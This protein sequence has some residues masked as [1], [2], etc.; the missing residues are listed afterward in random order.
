MPTNSDP[1]RC[2]DGFVSSEGGVDSNSDPALLPANELAFL[3]NGSLRSNFANTRPPYV[4]RPLTFQAGTAMSNFTGIFQGACFYESA[5]DMDNGLIVSVGGHLFKIL[6]NENFKVN[7]ITPNV[8]DVVAADFLVPAANSQV[9]VNVTGEQPFSVNQNLIIDSGIYVVNTILS[10]Q[11]VLTYLSSAANATVVEGTAIFD[12]AGNRIFFQQTNPA[13]ADFVYLYQA[14]NYV[15]GLCE[16]QKT[17][18]YDGSSTAISNQSLSQLPS[19][20]L[21]TYAWGRNWLAQVDGH[22]FIASDLVG[23]PSGTPSLNYVDAILKVT[24]NNVLNGGGSFSTPANLGNITAM[25]VLSQ[26]D[27]SLGIGPVLVG[28]LNSIFS[29]QAPVDRTTWQNLTFPIQSVAVQGSGP[30]GP[31]ALLPVNSDA[32]YRSLDG[33]RSMVAARRDFNTNLSNT[34]NSIEMSLVFDFDDPALLFY[35]SIASFDNRILFTA[36]PFRNINGVAHRGIVVLNQD[37]IS[38]IK[39][40]GNPIWEGLWTGLNVL[41]IVTGNVD[42]VNRCFLFVLNS[43]NN[44]EL[45]EITPESEDKEDDVSITFGTN[46]NLIPNGSVYSFLGKFNLIGILAPSTSYNVTFGNNDLSLTNTEGTPVSI[47]GAPGVFNFTT[48]ASPVNLYLTKSPAAIGRT[49]VTATISLAPNPTLV[50]TQ[51]QSWLE[52]RL[53]NFSD[54]FQL[55]RLIM[56]DLNLDKITDN[57]TMK[58][59]WRPDQYP[60]WSLWTTFNL[61]ANVSQCGFVGCVAGQAVMWK[62]EFKQYGARIRLPRPPELVN[63]ILNIPMEIG[64]EFQFRIEWTGGVRIRRFRASALE[65][66]SQQEGSCPPSS[67]CITLAGCLPQYYT[68]NSYG[69]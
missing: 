18:F 39:K 30:T 52:T 16:N 64:N 3:G 55:K 7:E 17:I 21:G 66:Q 45:W 48:G 24:E 33:V 62:T 54:P 13:N 41:Q 51:I 10:D 47:A 59:Y 40:D 15:I 29:V 8:T 25:S 53:M 6:V 68:Y 23:G 5:N 69:T 32:W 65:R 36:S 43:S 60:L 22:H 35:S 4:Q 2:Y 61:C 57:V 11:L 67:S 63:Q 27:S 26:L 37:D 1:K 49:G 50:Y 9:T 42:G 19:S 12:S 31:R 56:V 14:E 38:S 28:T 20:Y 58:V 44:I 46:P 34:P